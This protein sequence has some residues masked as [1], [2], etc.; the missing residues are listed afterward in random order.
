MSADL[1]WFLAG[2]LSTFGL[3][4]CQNMKQT[5]V[6]L[7][8]LK[9][10]DHELADF[11]LVHGSCFRRF[12]SNPHAAPKTGVERATARHRV[13]QVGKYTTRATP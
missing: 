7:A 9:I 12:G 11:L 1:T 4:H 6:L 3:S 5:L 2:I 10:N 13:A 8:R